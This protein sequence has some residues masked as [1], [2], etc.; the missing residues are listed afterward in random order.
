MSD[1]ADGSRATFTREQVERAVAEVAA[2]LPG[3]R[4]TDLPDFVNR[5][6]GY[7]FLRIEG[8]KLLLLAHER[9]RE[10]FRQEATELDELL[11][12]CFEKVTKQVA[13]RE[14]LARRRLWSRRDSRRRWFPRWVELMAGLD[15]AWGA[16]T[17]AHVDQVLAGYPYRG[18]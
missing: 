12:L 3:V 18:R 10:C 6:A 15:P 5:D 14:E 2:R 9:G 4:P 13:Q 8:E 11:Y 7:P 16:R 1:G 17:R